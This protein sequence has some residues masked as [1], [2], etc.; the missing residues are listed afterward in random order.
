MNELDSENRILE[1]LRD[2]PTAKVCILFDDDASKNVYESILN[3]KDNWIDNSSKSALPPDYI[4]SIDSIMMEVMRVNDVCSETNREESKMQH[5]LYDSGILKMFPNNINVCCVP[6]VHSQCYENYLKSFI[7][8]VQKHNSKIE[9]Y[10][11][12]H[13]D[14][15]KTVFLICDE[16]EAY[17]ELCEPTSNGFRGNAHQWFWD[18]RFMSVLKNTSVDI[19]IWFTPYKALERDGIDF[20]KVV[21]INPLLIDEGKFVEYNIARMVDATRIQ[22]VM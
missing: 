4:N 13:P 3:S 22:R 16:S 17:F 21:V 15:I 9:K 5:E 12:N 6:N 2:V 8:T 19:V 20:P 18:S 11:N 7:Q 10:K 14:I 1:Y